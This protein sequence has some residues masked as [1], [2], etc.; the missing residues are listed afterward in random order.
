MIED[1]KKQIREH[2]KY[3]LVSE[4]PSY[5]EVIEEYEIGIEN[6]KIPIQLVRYKKKTY[7]VVPYHNHIN[8]F[9]ELMGSPEPK[10]VLI[11][12]TKPRQ[13]A[14][15]DAYINLIAEVG[16]RKGLKFGGIK[17]YDF[18]DAK[19]YEDFLTNS[20]TTL[21]SVIDTVSPAIIVGKQK[22]PLSE[23]F[24]SFLTYYIYGSL[25]GEGVI[26]LLRYDD[27]LEEIMINGSKMPVYVYHYKFGK[28][29][30]NF[31]YLDEYKLYLC[32]KA[33][34]DMINRTISPKTPILD[35]SLPDN[36]RIQVTIPPASLTGTL[37]TV[38]KAK[39]TALSILHSIRSGI[40]DPLISA[41]LIC[42]G[43]TDINAIFVGNTG[44]AKS[45]PGHYAVFVKYNNKQYLLC[46][47]DLF[48]LGIPIEKKKDIE[49]RTL[50]HINLYVW[51]LKEGKPDWVRIKKVIKHRDK[52]PLL[53]ITG[54]T[55]KIQTTFDHNF[56]VKDRGNLLIVPAEKLSQYGKIVNIIPPDDFKIPEPYDKIFSKYYPYF[57]ETG[58][59]FDSL[60]ASLI[61][62]G[63]KINQIKHR[64]ER[65][66]TGYGFEYHIKRCNESTPPV[67]EESILD[68]R[69]VSN[70]YKYLYDIETEDISQSFVVLADYG[71]V[72]VHNTTHL[73]HV[74]N[75]IPP[76]DRLIIIEEVPE[77]VVFKDHVVRLLT[78]ETVSMEKHIENTLRMRPDRVTLGEIRRAEEFQAY[79]KSLIAGQAKAS[80]ATAHAETSMDILKRFREYGIPPHDLTTLNYIVVLRRETRVSEK[81]R[82]DIRKLKEIAEVQPEV[83]NRGYPVL[84]KIVTYDPEKDRWVWNTDLK[85]TLLVQKLS[86]MYGVSKEKAV[87]I[88]YE[89]AAFL[90]YVTKNKG[91]LYANEFVPLH[92]K[93]FYDQEE[94]VPKNVIEE[95]KERIK[96]EYES[97]RNTT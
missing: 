97:V 8:R 29:P 38:R 27:S 88:L 16:L 49:V 7:Y 90:E 35:I 73:M 20:L 24:R 10:Y 84:K 34:G 42:M 91:T 62:L 32:A 55:F 61:S 53:E 11:N 70:T 59:V 72:L 68:I 12:N 83:D 78:T 18:Q 22:I 86:W 93:Y 13:I 79:A 75:A 48:R 67:Y 71:F 65:I 85:D 3:I 1:S 30:T 44:S 31:R 94:I 25:T 77:L 52:R 92:D 6:I 37:I 40:L 14:N 60:T 2:P 66:K 96:K 33:Y 26:T 45:V 43:R 51:G 21:K 89:T 9:L 81:G 28:I 95:L 74:L 54:E 39:R 76:E 58:M 82:I 36:S 56:F 19:E 46:I 23:G 64:I 17:I 69:V 15:F 4:P 80:Y 63:L 47:H 87:D 5:D 57:L 50:E 41:F